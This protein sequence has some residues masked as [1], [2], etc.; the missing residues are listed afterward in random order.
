[1]IE[2][3]HKHGYT[4]SHPDILIAATA[5]QHGLIVVTRN[6]SE[7]VAAGVASLNPW[8]DPI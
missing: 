8:K 4:Y 6:T 3:G 2:V 5:A 1:M 7:L